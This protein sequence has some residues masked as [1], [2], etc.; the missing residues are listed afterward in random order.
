MSALANFLFLAVM[1]VTFATAFHGTAILPFTFSSTSFARMNHCSIDITPLSSSFAGAFD[2]D[3]MDALETRGELEASLMEQAGVGVL[4]GGKKKNSSKKKQ[5]E[6]KQKASVAARALFQ[7]GVVQLNGILSD[8][9]ASSLRE[10]ILERRAGAYAAV[11]NDS[12][13]DDEWRK[14]FADVLL[15]G[16]QNQRC[17]LLLPLKGWRNLQLALHELL[18]SKNN[19]LPGTIISACSG[20]DDATLYELSALISE[21]GSSRQPVHPDNPH[22]EEPPLF[23]VFIAL[24]DIEMNMGPTSFIPRTHN[25]VAH[26][27]YNDVPQGRDDLLRSRKSAV[28]LLNV[29]DASLFDSRSLHC[30]GANN[31]ATR[32][33]L[34]MSFRNPRA[35]EPIGN[36]GSIMPDIPR[37]TLAELR[38][39]LATAAAS[40]Q[41]NKDENNPPFDPFDDEQEAEKAMGELHRI[42]KGGDAL[43]Q[44]QLGTNYYL[45]EGGFETDLVEAVRWFELAASQGNARAQF[46]LGFCCSTGQGMER[47]LQ[48]A[49]GLFRLASEQSHPGAKE[50]YEET[51]RELEVLKD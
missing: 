4:N 26:A 38:A 24:Q 16:H 40:D 41:S 46:N 22:Q 44:L 20:H 28:A 2:V 42:A 51:L 8:T 27:A 36:V 50:V 3:Q 5:K 29:G 31:G 45:S 11:E 30:G 12:S 19:L 14:H 49:V 17:D 25:A 33:L 48:R 18:T 32:V 9:T 35:T 15:R 43:A 7:D 37:M 47:D 34:Y 6:K 21:P 23:T 13:G 1:T 10:E 39:K